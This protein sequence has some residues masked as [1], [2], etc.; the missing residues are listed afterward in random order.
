LEEEE[1]VVAIEETSRETDKDIADF[2]LKIHDIM[3]GVPETENADG[4][5]RNGDNHAQSPVKKRP[6]SSKPFSRR[7]GACNVSP[8]KRW[9]GLTIN[10]PLYLLFGI[11]CPYLLLC[12]FGT[13]STSQA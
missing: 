6:G 11:L 10:K 4:D 1:K 9:P 5:S 8:T 12:Y 3:N 7:V 13:G 2:S